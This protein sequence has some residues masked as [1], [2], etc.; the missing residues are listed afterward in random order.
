VCLSKV[1][2]PDIHWSEERKSKL[3]P[4]ED[5]ARERVRRHPRVDKSSYACLELFPSHGHVTIDGR[6]HY[7]K[8]F[9]QL[10]EVMLSCWHSL[11]TSYAWCFVLACANITLCGKMIPSLFIHLKRMPLH[12][13]HTTQLL[14][15]PLVCMWMARWLKNV[16]ALKYHKFVILRPSM[17]AAVL[18]HISTIDGVFNVVNEKCE[19]IKKKEK[20]WP[21]SGPDGA[22]E[23][24]KE[25]HIAI[26]SHRDLSSHSPTASKFKPLRVSDFH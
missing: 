21:R 19:L 25:K 4:T 6:S 17:R 26:I 12:A 23:I 5:W 20:R 1:I 10:L 22:Y 9:L 11:S 2:K 16:S 15:L 18:S 13:Y 3:N 14:S 8:T 7:L 24:T